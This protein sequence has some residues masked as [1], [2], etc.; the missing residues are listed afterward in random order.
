MRPDNTPPAWRSIG[1]LIIDGRRCWLRIGPGAGGRIRLAPEPVTR[2]GPEVPFEVL[3]QARAVRGLI[4]MLR[5][6]LYRMLRRIRRS[7]PSV[8]RHGK[9]A[10]GR[11]RH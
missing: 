5:A 11:V 9:H 1:P 6:A 3:E 10:R 8:K 2:P 7:R 4:L